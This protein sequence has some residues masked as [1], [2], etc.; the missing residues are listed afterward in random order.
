M[1]LW[2]LD[3]LCIGL[4]SALMHMFSVASAAA[5]VT[6]SGNAEHMSIELSEAAP[7]AEVVSDIA[8]VLDVPVH[9]DAGNVMARPNRLSG[10]NL[11]QALASFLPHRPFTIRYHADGITPM[12]ITFPGASSPGG[13]NSSGNSLIP[14]STID[15]NNRAQV[16]V[17]MDNRD[18][19][20]KE[21]PMLRTQ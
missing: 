5:V 19:F 7:A 2:R 9:G 3:S 16:P 20:I 18:Q 4:V 17:P 6:V 13:I 15:A 10:V 8:R 1:E 12:A 14:S 21:L 11:H